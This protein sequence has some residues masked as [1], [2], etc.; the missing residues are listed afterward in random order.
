MKKCFFM[1]NIVLI[2]VVFLVAGCGKKKV[3]EKRLSL[4]EQKAIV[5]EILKNGGDPDTIVENHIETDRSDNIV[6]L[7]FFNNDSIGKIPE[8]IGKLT[9]LKKL[10]ITYT[11]GYTAY[12][13]YIPESIVNLKNLKS[14]AIRNCQ[15]SEFPKV[16]C[17]LIS[18]DSLDMSGNNFTKIS[19]EIGN[20]KNLTCVDFSYNKI[21]DIPTTF[22]KLSKLNI[23]WLSYNNIKTLP[24]F[25]GCLVA[26][27]AIMLDNN[28]L[29]NT[30]KFIFSLKNLECVH[31]SNNDSIP[32]FDAK[33]LD[34][35]NLRELTM[36]GN[37]IKRSSV[38]VE[39][40][41]IIDKK[42]PLWGI[43]DDRKE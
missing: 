24:D 29:S 40:R 20:L 30:P 32:A 39:Y 12:V 7:H 23:L 17:E 35:V 4:Q 31:L 8:S 10:L 14:L 34:F 11:P 5:A 36:F 13:Q 19:D 2:S 22:C 37:G 6:Y 16:V 3:E 1:V 28:H 38:S 25:S 43:F 41:T 33:F 26:L 42:M 18:L 15:M 21:E 9:N 27:K